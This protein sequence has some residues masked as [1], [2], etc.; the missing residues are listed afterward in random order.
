MRKILLVGNCPLPEENTKSRPAAG[1]RTYQFFEA[2]INAGFFVKL[3]TIAMP[4]C[5]E[6]NS[7]LV[8]EE[9]DSF[10][11]IS[12]SKD[13]PRL[14][15]KIQQIYD[16]FDPE[17]VVS[18]N[19]YPSYITSG[20]RINCPV[21]ADLN[22]WI[23]AEAQAQ[24]YKIRSNAYIPHYSK[25]QKWIL[26]TADKFSSVSMG[27]KYAL[28]GELAS[29]NRLNRESFGYDFVDLI[30]NATK[31]FDNEIFEDDSKMPFNQKIKEIDENAFILLWMGGYNT[32]VDETTLFDAV[33]DAMSVY[34]DI[35]FVSTGGEIPGLDN[36]TFNRFKMMVDKSV[37]KDRFV[38]LGWVDSAE[39]P[40]LYKRADIGLNVDR[41]CVETITGAR[42][43]INE[44]MK[45]GLPVLTT[46]GSEISYEVAVNNAGI[47]VPSG[48]HEAL[49]YSILKMYEEK[50][51][52]QFAKYG[53]AGMEYTQKNDYTTTV[54]PLLHWLKNPTP[55][56]DRG[57]R[58]NKYMRFIKYLKENGIKKSL[59]KL[60]R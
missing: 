10:S 12:L 3:V 39:I 1:L 51:T 6:K 58:I 13:D 18:V 21:W 23:M 35:Y 54:K 45:F 8:N 53:E 14:I 46:A 44:M 11:R 37:F 52:P 25:M 17:A 24:A 4:E 19:T 50:G 7:P 20:I 26:R 41:M 5:Y 22:G 29:L 33:E 9:T 27:E 49:A 47:V 42:N 59:K 32:W 43:R 15:K 55:A 38:F 60:L 36:E 31:F 40:S 16:D 28:L 30:P 57:V 48:K 56:P 2:L 34:E